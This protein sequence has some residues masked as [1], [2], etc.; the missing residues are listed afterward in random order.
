MRTFQVLVDFTIPR[1]TL[2]FYEIIRKPLAIG[3]LACPLQLHR[4]RFRAITIPILI[5]KPQLLALRKF[6]SAFVALCSEGSII[7]ICIQNYLFQ[8]HHY[9]HLS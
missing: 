6:H 7:L 5:T 2:C 3:L 9:L 4:P 1:I 8:Y